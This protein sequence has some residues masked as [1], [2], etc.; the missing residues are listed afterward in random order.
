MVLLFLVKFLKKPSW[1]NG[2]WL[3]IA[4]MGM[5]HTHIL[6]IPIIAGEVF[7]YL[8]AYIVY[9]R[10]N[11]DLFFFLYKKKAEFDLLKLVLVLSIVIFSY[12]VWLPVFY[13]QFHR[14]FLDMLP[15]KFAQKFGFDGFYAVML[16]AIAMVVG[17]VSVLL[18]FAGSNK[19]YVRIKNYLLGLKFP[20]SLFV[21]VFL[22]WLVLNLFYHEHFFGNLFYVRYLL[23]LFPLWYIIA[24]RKLY[25]LRRGFGLLLVLYLLVSMAVLHSYYTIDGKEQWREVVAY[26]EE[27]AEENDVLLFHTAGHTHW[28]FNYYYEGLLPQVKLKSKNDAVKISS[29]VLDKE[30]AFLILSHNYETKEYFKE[31][32]DRDYHLVE[33]KVFVGVKVYKYKVS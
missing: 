12:L 30:Y 3:A 4:N 27:E 17:A 14:L 20:L 29:A 11:E 33:S 7:L 1:W 24:A 21:V 5:L 28:A 32:M 10:Q 9:T 2:I 31:V 16:A 15:L 18:Y 26:V 25:G 8:L 13:F 22:G 23:F 19:V 6:S